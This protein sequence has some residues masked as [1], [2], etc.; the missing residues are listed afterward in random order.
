MKV[1][2]ILIGLVTALVVL[3]GGVTTGT[4]ITQAL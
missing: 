2:R 1:S 3:A 4:F